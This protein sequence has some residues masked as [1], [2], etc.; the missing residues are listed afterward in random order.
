MNFSN[1]DFVLFVIFFIL[2]V[3]YYLKK[4]KFSKIDNEVSVNINNIEKKNII[5]TIENSQKNVVI[6]Y[7]S[8]TGT[9]EAYAIKLMKDLSSTFGLD[10]MVVDF[11]DYDFTYFSMIKPE[12]FCFFIM[13]TYGEGDPPDNAI[14]FFEFLESSTEVFSSLKYSIFGLGNSTYEFYNRASKRL[15]KIFLELGATEFL[16]F[17]EGDDKN[18]NSD[19]AFIAWKKDVYSFFKHKKKV[20]EVNLDYKPLLKVVKRDD[21]CKDHPSVVI[22][23]PNIKYDNK[24]QEKKAINN[25][26]IYLSEIVKIEN[27]YHSTERSCLHIEFDLS[28][29]NLKYSTGDHLGVWPFNC[30]DHINKFLETFGLENKKNDVIDV[31]VSD[32]MLKIPFES[33]IT[34]EILVKYYLAINGPFSKQIL[35]NLRIFAPDEKSKKLCI[36]LSK[37]SVK[38][39]N[40]IAQKKLN[41][42]EALLLISNGKI[43]DKVTL[44]FLMESLLFIKPRFYSI[45][46]SSLAKKKILAITVI[47][48]SEKI[49]DRYVI[50]LTTNL[51]KCFSSFKNINETKPCTYF[52]IKDQLYDNKKI[53]FPIFIRK[54]NFKIPENPSTP[55]ILIGP[56]TGVA[57]FRGFLMEKTAM[58]KKKIKIGKILL[59]YG[60]RCNAEFLYSKEWDAYKKILDPD[61]EMF[62]SFSQEQNKA[63][64]YV[65]S[66]LLENSDKIRDLLNH[67]AVIYICGDALKMAKDVQKTLSK[68]ILNTHTVSDKDVKNLLKKLIN[69]NKY[70]EDVW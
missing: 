14:D 33:P 65:Q 53:R 2:I 42:H 69:E 40:M 50:G 35:Y 45:S 46:S 61:F 10:T 63:K 27:L 29:T 3:F 6:F 49:D 5:S 39:E 56:G 9:A 51:F 36:E 22:N 66:K 13:S 11:S 68:I 28:K 24:L 52:N 47:V 26:F 67:G 62:V 43:W 21:I 7:G 41:F 8:Q 20:K 1:Y 32:Q 60:C 23:K 17:A 19:D 58:K 44:D 34:Y 15:K 70:K 18:G 30:E 57:P 16:P 25:N 59:F 12:V 48:E 38:F 31:Q 4:V 37:D 64:E 55:L 54:S